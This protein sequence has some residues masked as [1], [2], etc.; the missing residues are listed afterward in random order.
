MHIKLDGLS[1]LSNALKK[2][3]KSIT[4][5]LQRVVRKH[6]ASL[7]QKAMRLV[8]VDTGT[9]KRSITLDISFTGLTATVEPHTEYAA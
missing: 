4:P 8:P 7:Q 2:K 1:L 6:G 9:L 5:D 3:T